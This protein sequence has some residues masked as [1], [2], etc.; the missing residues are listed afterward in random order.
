MAK[1][2]GAKPNSIE[3]QRTRAQT[4]LRTAWAQRHARKA[5]E[6]RAL[7][8]ERAD[9]QRDFAHKRHGT[10]ET[11]HHASK[12]RQGAIARLYNS[13]RLA[14]E[15]VAWAQE[16]RTVAERIGAD[17]AVSTASLET[18]VDTSRHGDVFWEALGAVR[19]EVAYSRW[20]AQLGGRAAIALDIIVEDAAVTEVARRYRVSARKAGAL[21][22]EA[23]G[24]WGRLIQ[25]ACKE[26]DAATLAAAQAGLI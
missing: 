19:A 5:A 15:E 4:Q 11:H 16:I 7:R 20:R 13:G 23:L 3:A 12:V 10:P 18:R 14:I 8:K 25:Q 2:K 21:L 22:E 26:V 1:A 24:L 9:L 6:E 17:V